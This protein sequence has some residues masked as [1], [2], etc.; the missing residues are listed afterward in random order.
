MTLTCEIKR[1]EGYC[2]QEGF[3]EIAQAYYFK[4]KE[5]E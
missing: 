4:D 1:R 5:I 2:D 3:N